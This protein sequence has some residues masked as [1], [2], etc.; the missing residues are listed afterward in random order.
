MECEV[1]CFIVACNGLSGLTRVW[2][3]SLPERIEQRHTELDLG[4]REPVGCLWWG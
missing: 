1:W 4:I 2:Q 3:T